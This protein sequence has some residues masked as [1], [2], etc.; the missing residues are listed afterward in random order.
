MPRPPR[1]KA[2]GYG[3]LAREIEGL[4]ENAPSAPESAAAP[5]APAPGAAT[6][7]A[8]WIESLSGS[9]GGEACA[10]GAS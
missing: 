6:L 4:A 8:R 10:S 2:R 5:R 7:L 3:N 9:A 1:L